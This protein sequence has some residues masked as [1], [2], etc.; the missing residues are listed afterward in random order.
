MVNAYLF[1]TVRSEEAV[2][3]R[4]ISAGLG[5]L[6]L[7]FQTSVA[8]GAVLPTLVPYS[9]L[10]QLPK[11]CDDLRPPHETPEAC[12]SHL[13]AMSGALGS[14]QTLPG[15]LSLWVDGRKGPTAQD[16]QYRGARSPSEQDFLLLEPLAQ[17]LE[18]LLAEMGELKLQGHLSPWQVSAVDDLSAPIFK[19]FRQGYWSVPGIIPV[20]NSQPFA[21][22]VEVSFQVELAWKDKFDTSAPGRV[23][24]PAS[25]TNPENQR[26]GAK[27]VTYD[28]LCGG[29]LVSPSW[30]LT[31]AHCVMEQGSANK[32]VDKAKLI[33]HAG[34]LRLSDDSGAHISP[35]VLIVQIKNIYPHEDYRPSRLN[36]PPENDLALVELQAPVPSHD[37]VKY[38]WIDYITPEPAPSQAVS[39]SGWGAMTEVTAQQQLRRAQQPSSPMIVPMSRDLGKITLQVLPTRD[40][41]NGLNRQLDVVHLPRL[42]RLP[43]DSFCASDQSGSKKVE[44]TCQGDSGGPIVAEDKAFEW[45]ERFGPAYAEIEDAA[46]KGSIYKTSTGKKG[47]SIRPSILVGLVGWSVGCGVAPTV[48]TRVSDHYAWIRKK[49]TTAASTP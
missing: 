33:V 31:A 29:V 35:D 26:F 37:P 27:K 9:S 21:E 48:F 13:K 39:S 40:C 18:G 44:A 22:Q 6:L 20:M 2:M 16:I 19:F 30:V 12:R 36:Q 42:N 11:G 14:V 7:V 17:D 10:S 49:I 4:S 15:R 24:I 5:F 1:T 45:N 47:V 8:I 43:A 38:R 41:L 23:R 25:W 28:H 32:L 34:A 3:R 46:A